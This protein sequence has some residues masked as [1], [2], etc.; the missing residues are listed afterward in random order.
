[1]RLIEQGAVSL[2]GE[3]V[4]EREATVDAAGEHLLQRGKR[5]FA[6]VLFVDR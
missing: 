2:D 1:V 3:R 6:K 4:T 5:H